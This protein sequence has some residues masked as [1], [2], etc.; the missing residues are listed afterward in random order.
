MSSFTTNHRKVSVILLTLALLF[1]TNSFCDA[2]ITPGAVTWSYSVAGKAYEGAADSSGNIYFGTKLGIVAIDKNGSKRWSYETGA[3]TSGIPAI[4][5][6]NGYIYIVS[7]FELFSFTSSGSLRFRKEFPFSGACSTNRYW[8]ASLGLGK[9]GSIYAPVRPGL[10][11]FSPEGEVKWVFRQSADSWYYFNSP[12]VDADGV[13]YSLSDDG[14]L[15]AINPDGTKNWEK[16][17]GPNGSDVQ[18]MPALGNNNEIYYFRDNTLFALKNDG[19]ELWQRRFEETISH[20]ASPSVGADGTIYIPAGNNLYAITSTNEVRWIGTSD[21]WGT[22]DGVPAVG[23][24]GSV[25]VN[26]GRIAM[27]GFDSQGN[28]VWR[29]P[30]EWPSISFSPVVG[31]E[32]RTFFSGAERSEPQQVNAYTTA[33]SQVWSYTPTGN[34][35]TNPVTLHPSG[36]IWILPTTYEP[37]TVL[38]KQGN[39]KWTSSISAVEG[40]VINNK[41]LGILGQND[42]LISISE[43]GEKQT[44][45][46]GESG[47]YYK[48]ALDSKGNIY[49]YFYGGFLGAKNSIIKVD[50]SG[51]LKWELSDII[52]NDPGGSGGEVIPTIGLD[53]TIYITTIDSL[54]AYDPNGSEKWKVSLGEGYAQYPVVLGKDDLIIVNNTYK[55]GNKYVLKIQAYSSKGESKW[56]HSIKLSDYIFFGGW[57]DTA[58]GANG[59]LY[60]TTQGDVEKAALIALDGRNGNLLW[61]VDGKFSGTPVIGNDGVIYVVQSTGGVVEAISKNGTTLWRKELGENVSAAPIMDQYGTLY[62]GTAS[63]NLYAVATGA[64]GPASSPWPMY[65]HDSRHT[66]RAAAYEEPPPVLGVNPGVRLLLLDGH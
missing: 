45:F 2:E 48:P 40:P 61:Q 18:G 29:L 37:L 16:Q 31:L 39:L 15:Y 26:A 47:F 22:F 10:V 49:F 65:R 5:E 19:S 3:E 59:T 9:D 63:G 17:V 14:Y 12:V 35:L 41:G 6:V 66:G 7:G 32:N 13:I 25:T 34:P 27:C 21:Y 28:L 42:D 46:S 33:G 56:E 38:D 44:Y 23:S 55:E 20:D 64:T 60:A 50:A 52:P 54:Y 57:A 4:D 24:D 43:D 30:L 1:S 51:G 11:A 58:V 53:D 8:A 62:V 36:D